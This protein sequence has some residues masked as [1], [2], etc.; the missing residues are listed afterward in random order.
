MRLLVAMTLTA[1][2]LAGCGGGDAAEETVPTVPEGTP[3]DV[4]LEISEEGGFVPV[5]FNL[6]R[7][8]RFTVFAD[9]TVVAP[10]GEQF[11]FPGPAIPRM[12]AF[13]VDEPTLEDLLT[14]V[15]DL[16]LAEIES[17]D[18]NNA[19]NVA[20]ASTTVVRYFDEA[21]E[22]R[23]SIYALGFESGD[24]REAIVTSMISMLDEASHSSRG[25]VWQGDR[26][27]V[28]AQTA[29]GL[30]PQQL[31]DAGA[32]PF[33]FDRSDQTSEF[34]GFWCLTLDGEAA[35]SVTELLT[36]A[37]SMTTWNLDGEAYRVIGRPLLPH[38]DGC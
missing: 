2:V 8:P 4:I 3:G 22:H 24:A 18:I 14:F 29:Q 34:A 17:E 15:T 33:G 5:E 35:V 30:D 6:T 27:V 10:E 19:T 31:T 28:F 36:E 21:G 9:G 12:K 16:G 37:D 32:W 13:R 25:T 1:L 38:Q 20:D 11:A 7:V 26:I 23:L